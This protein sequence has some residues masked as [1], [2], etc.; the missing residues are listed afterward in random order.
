MANGGALDFGNGDERE[1]WEMVRDLQEE[2][3]EIS[4]NYWKMHEQLKQ[5]DKEIESLK[6]AIKLIKNG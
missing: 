5:K 6:Q 1:I 4:E 3:K 2:S